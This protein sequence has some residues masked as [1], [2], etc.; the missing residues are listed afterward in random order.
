MKK[1]IFGIW[2]I[3]LLAMVFNTKSISTES[4]EYSTK[5]YKDATNKTNIYTDTNKFKTGIEDSL[6]Y[7]TN[8]FDC[9]LSSNKI[10]CS[11]SSFNKVGIFSYPEYTHIGGNDSY[12]YNEKEYFVLNN[13]E[14]LNLTINGLD[15]KS[16]SH[17]RATIYLNPDANVTGTGKQDDP[18]IITVE[19]CFESYDGT[20]TC[21]LKNGDGTFGNLPTPERTGYTF[22]GWFTEETGGTQITGTTKVSEVT[23]KKLYDRWVANTYTISYDLQNGSHG[24]SHPTNA[25]YD[26]ALTINNPSK[27]ITFHGNQNTTSG[28]YGT[29][30]TIGANTTNTQTFNGW[31]ITNMDTTTHNIGSETSTSASL[32]NVKATSFK[33]LRGTKDTVNFK[34]KWTAVASSLP[35]ISKTGY[36]CG[37][38]ASNTATSTEVIANKIQNNTS[39]TVELYAVCTENSY[40]ITINCT[41]CKFGTTTSTSKTILYTQSDTV[42]ITPD[43]NYTMT[44]ATVTGSGCTLNEST[45]VLTVT[46]AQ[47]TR[48]CSVS[49]K[50]AYRC[51]EGDMIADLERGKNSGGYICVRGYTYSYENTYCSYQPCLRE[52]GCAYYST[53][54]EQVCGIECTYTSCTSYEAGNPDYQYISDDGYYCSCLSE[55]EVCRDKEVEYCVYNTCLEYGSCQSWSGTGTYT[56]TCN[57]GW[58]NYDGS[59]SSLR[60]YKAATAG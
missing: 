60:C 15:D 59:G 23:G 40:T 45:G 37:W 38:A 52:G 28:A 13:T 55:R 12:L 50:E 11:S 9:S 41:N 46:G 57:N 8:K 30:V 44:G 26:V 34:A 24:S 3:L 36:T 39:T 18:Y 48:T 5:T 27:T 21:R 49:A 19:I 32:N 43:T 7:D 33:N 16:S 53:R 17:L 54:T 56:Y 58:S 20:E 25:T 14:I 31:D 1:V 47:G 6:L 51:P 29:G 2:T 4:K 42:T 35:T 22:L 10:N